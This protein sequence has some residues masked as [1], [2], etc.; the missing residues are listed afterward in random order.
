MH[1]KKGETLK[2]S[3]SDMA[4]FVRESLIAVIHSSPRSKAFSPQ[5]L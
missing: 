3:I 1:R 5:Y 4:P 2:S